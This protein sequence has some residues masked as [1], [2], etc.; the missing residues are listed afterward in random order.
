MK[1]KSNDKMLLLEFY[2]TDR[3]AFELVRSDSMAVD[4]MD[5]KWHDHFGVPMPGDPL[6]S[7]EITDCLI[8]PLFEISVIAGGWH[9]Q[10]NKRLWFN[11]QYK[12]IYIKEGKASSIE[13]ALMDAMTF[14]EE[15]LIAEI[16]KDELDKMMEAIANDENLSN[17]DT[18]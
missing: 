10:V 11:N 6:A 13:D 15:M 2:G 8:E 16:G 14:F 18:L 3:Y 12:V 9:W 5:A 17:R 1:A 4:L 7:W